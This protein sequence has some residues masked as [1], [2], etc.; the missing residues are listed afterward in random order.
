MLVSSGAKSGPLTFPMQG[1]IQNY[2]TGELSVVETPPPQLRNGWV[3]VRNS[4]SLISAGTEKTKVDTAS[5]SLLGKAMARPDLVKK[6]IAKAAREGLWKAWQ[7]AS[8]R[9]DQPIALGYS[10]AG[11]VIGTSGDV[12]GLC[13]G[14]WVACG[15]STAN[16]AEIVCVPKNL[17]VAIPE[18]VKTDAAAF[19]TVGAIAM[20][21]VRQADVRLGEQV[22]VI[23]LGLVGLLTVQILRASGCRV[24]GIDVDPA[25]LALAKGLGCDE[26]ALAASEQLV[27]QVL[28]FTDGFGVD[29]TI[30]TAGTSSNSPVEQ[31]AEITREKGKVVV[32]GLT[33]MNIPREPF[34]HKELDLRLS[35]SYGPGRYDRRYEEEGIDYPHAYVRFTEGRNLACFLQLLR[36]GQVRLDRIITH[37]FPIERA[38]DAYDLIRGPAKEPYLG[39][40]LEYR[41]E[42]AEIATRIE[43][44]SPRPAGAE[45]R[46]GVI[47]AGNYACS[48]LLPTLQRI[49]TVA[50]GTICTGSGVS[51]VRVARKFGFAAASGNSEEIIAE[52]DAVIIGTRHNDHARW[53]IEALRAGK[54][55]FVEKPLAISEEELDQVIAQLDECNADGANSARNPKPPAAAGASL[56]VGFNRRFAPAVSLVRNHFFQVTAPKQLVM[57][58]NA[59]PI[60]RDHWVHDPKVGGGRLI[61]EGCHFVDLAVCLTGQLITRVSAMGIEKQNLAPALWDDF[62]LVL[63][64]ADGSVATVIY[65]SVGDAGMPKERVELSGGG[66]TAVIE[67]FR[68]VELWSGGRCARKRWW[69]Q[70]KGQAA[71]MKAW[72]DSLRQGSWPIPLEQLINVHRACFAA[73]RSMRDSVAVT[74]Q[75]SVDGGVINNGSKV[76][77]ELVTD[78]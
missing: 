22:A 53:V 13:P 29:A 50:L 10:C 73:I 9:L 23:G 66:R 18:G 49:P 27:E 77:P 76:A 26:I 47:G 57:R 30:I 72:V 36:A 1:V 21:G 46:L 65:T 16:H 6:V 5:K 51:A 34:Y 15:G 38:A 20:Q 39:I 28:G 71:E 31:A 7:A 55:V 32:V 44:T 54:S 35:R 17:A 40:L 67:D 58:V 12:N 14:D 75:T 4:H 3:L 64:L 69:A 25:K 63:Q 52:S 19:T 56:T 62:S 48:Y 43:L 59:G 24:F 68:S 37:R 70:D 42:S 60:A 41:R 2:K 8:D 61:G 78:R 45:I 33:G 74:L 11:Q